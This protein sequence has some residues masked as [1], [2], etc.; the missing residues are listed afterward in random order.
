MRAG[1]LKPFWSS[2][3]ALS[4]L[5]ASHLPP[6]LFTPTYT[7]RLVHGSRCN[8]SS[9]PRI[10]QF[11]RAFRRAPVS[12]ERMK[13]RS[14]VIEREM[15]KENTLHLLTDLGRQV[16]GLDRPQETA[17]RPTIP[18]PHPQPD[19]YSFLL[20]PRDT[21][22]LEA[23]A[24]AF[25]TG[26]KGGGQCQCTIESVSPDSLTATVIHT[27]DSKRQEVELHRLRPLHR[28]PN[29]ISLVC[30]STKH[31]RELARHQVSPH[32]TVLEIGASFG[33]ATRILSKTGARHVTAIDNSAE[34]VQHIQAMNLPNVSVHCVQALSNQQSDILGL[35]PRPPTV[36]LVDIGGNRDLAAVVNLLAWLSAGIRP[37]LIITKSEE[38]YKKMEERGAAFSYG[39]VLE[40]QAK[41]WGTDL[42]A[43]KTLNKIP[44][45][46]GGEGKRRICTAH[47]YARGG[48]APPNGGEC[49]LCHERCHRCL[50]EGHVART[51]TEQ[52]AYL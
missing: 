17:T 21:P 46:S 45:V 3:L 43:D 35:L 12:A 24:F 23:G 20:H 39:E 38:L 19:P 9:K 51:C 2:C 27:S 8:D 41:T 30:F 32:D 7:Q 44:C 4:S 6:P 16:F 13:H 40:E 36:V 48:C 5:L 25:V 14:A 33:E 10:A 42:R 15:R 26:R 37:P 28:S 22:P 18:S 31:F 29:P 52:F 50:A 1:A 47:N 11:V 49:G 34:G